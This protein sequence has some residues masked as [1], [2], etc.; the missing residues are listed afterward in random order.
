M[1]MFL[2]GL[3]VQDLDGVCPSSTIPQAF[4]AIWD[5][6]SIFWDVDTEG[7]ITLTSPL[8]YLLHMVLAVRAGKGVCDNLVFLWLPS[9]ASCLGLEAKVRK[10]GEKAGADRTG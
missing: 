8:D 4:R 2:A 5:G 9:L 6:R 1:C 7:L 10:C 3:E